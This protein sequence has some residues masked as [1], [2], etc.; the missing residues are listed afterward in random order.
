[1]AQPHRRLPVPDRDGTEITRGCTVWISHPSHS[2][3]GR[4]A[5][6]DAIERR[7]NQ[8]IV[9]LSVYSEV[10]ERFIHTQAGHRSVVVR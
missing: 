7:K 6:V 4:P 3:Y 9:R 2:Y 8:T 1:M 5:R 10:L